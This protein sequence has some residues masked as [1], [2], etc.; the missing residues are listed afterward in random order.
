[1]VNSRRVRARKGGAAGD[2]APAPVLTRAI[3]T[4][5]IPFAHAGPFRPPWKPQRRL[6][7]RGA[8][9]ENRISIQTLGTYR[10]DPAS[11][12]RA[13]KLPGK[14]PCG[15]ELRGKGQS[16]PAMHLLHSSDSYG[17]FELRNS[18]RR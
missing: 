3:R 16:A 12:G 4:A 6:A 13:G 7:R 8:V 17:L 15:E 14:Q 2:I 11:P 9:A 5:G 18:A 10:L 1:M